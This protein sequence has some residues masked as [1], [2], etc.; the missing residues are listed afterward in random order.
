[1]QGQEEDVLPHTHKRFLDPGKKPKEG[2]VN[3]DRQRKFSQIG[4]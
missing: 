4:D 1:M 2:A 3:E